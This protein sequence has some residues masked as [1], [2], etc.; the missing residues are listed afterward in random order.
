M[1]RVFRLYG[2]ML[3]VRSTDKRGATP[4]SNMGLESIVSDLS[5]ESQR[6]M[7]LT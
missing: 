5:P 1:R 7:S 2:N 4:I 3:I 6:I